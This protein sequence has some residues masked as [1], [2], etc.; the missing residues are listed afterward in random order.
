V[1]AK[2]E[3]LRKL[4]AFLEEHRIRYM[5]IGGLANMVWGRPR[6]TYDA[7]VKV[8]L[9][10]LSISEFGELVGRHFAYRRADAIDFARRAYVL[11]VQLTDDVPAD[12]IIGLLPY[13]IQAIERAVQVDVEDVALQVCTAEDL[14]IHKAVSQREKDWS[15]IEGILLRQEDKLDQHY[16]LDWLEQFGDV[17]ERPTILTRYESLRARLGV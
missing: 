2:T 3:A 10:D 16:V 11:L 8:L 5:V 6:L 13:E 12:L 15:D 14:I 7:D 9:G 17:L 1:S 4:G